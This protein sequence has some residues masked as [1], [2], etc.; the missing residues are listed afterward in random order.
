MT[1][2]LVVVVISMLLGSMAFAW[3]RAKRMRC[4]EV[5][6]NLK[7]VNER[8]EQLELMNRLLEASLNAVP[9]GLVVC[10][11]EGSDI[12]RNAAAQVFVEA[13]HGDALVEQ[14]IY[15]V[16]NSAL[17]GE[18]AH[19]DLDLIGPP[20]RMISVSALPLSERNHRFGSVV[21]VDDVSERRRIDDVRRDFV[22]NISHELKTPVGALGLLAET[23]STEDD[24]EVVQ[25]LS[26]RM[27]DEAF[28]VARMIDDL[29]DLS[30]I[31]AD[32]GD[33]AEAVSLYQVI[34]AATER[35]KSIARDR[36]IAIDL[37]G[38]GQDLVV[39]V[40]ESQLISAV[41][42]LL[43]NACKYSDENSTVKV[44]TSCAG[45]WIEIAVIDS[46]IGIPARDL[47]RVFERFYRVDRARSR[48]TG[49]TGLGLSIVRHVLSNHGGEVHVQSVEGEG[50][51][52]M[53]RLPLG[54]GKADEI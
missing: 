37:H 10:D 32:E 21:I 3:I 11:D 18:P 36:S 29:L 5:E 52:F 9:Q 2:L 48:E 50:S 4:S 53:L 26:R 8:V 16:I 46:G 34:T 42:N 39:F 12:L 19:R 1:T 33:K 47:E 27:T 15:E 49:G 51:T 54:L 40:D 13:R 14:A 22:A 23:I 7:I 44:E 28:R 20:Q 17:I 25:R 30:R 43:E 31:E 24:L 45:S 41:G 38:V 6:E 35:V